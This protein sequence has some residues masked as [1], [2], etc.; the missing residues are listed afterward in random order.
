MKN[1]QKISKKSLIE[2]LLLMVCI[3]KGVNGITQLI[4]L[5]NLI[6]RNS[7]LSCQSSISC[8]RPNDKNLKEE[9]IT[10][11]FT[12]CSAEQEHFLQQVTRRTS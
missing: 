10:C 3:W 2:A 1:N 7:S 11:Q 6:Q 4:S 12:K 8:P 9:Y 5:Q